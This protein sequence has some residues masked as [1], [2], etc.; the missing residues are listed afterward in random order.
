MR[1]TAVVP[2]SDFSDLWEARRTEFP[3]GYTPRKAIEVE[4]GTPDV[5][6]EEI[7]KEEPSNLPLL[8]L[9]VGGE[10]YRLV[11]PISVRIYRD[12]KWVFAE[13]E[14]LV[15]SGN[16]LT[17]GEAMLELQEHIVHFWNYYTQIPEGQLLIEGRRLK[18]IYSGLFLER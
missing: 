16:G 9:K 17:I 15:L 8:A 3:E 6:I 13:N 2:A 5:D 18:Q 10:R 12:G 11:R 14:V 1:T 4:T 7:A